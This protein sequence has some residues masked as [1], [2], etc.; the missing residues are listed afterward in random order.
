MTMLFRH[1]AIK[2]SILTKMRA[3]AITI[4]QGTLSTTRVH[5]AVSA[6]TAAAVAS[7]NN[8]Y[9]NHSDEVLRSSAPIWAAAALAVG[10]LLSTTF[11]GDD[12]TFDSIMTN[13]NRRNKTDC[14]GIAGVVGTTNKTDARYEPTQNCWMGVCVLL[15]LLQ[16]LSLGITVW[17]VQ[18]NVGCCL[19]CCD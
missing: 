6:V 12:A 13:S 9:Y 4:T 5:N 19:V 14:C 1:R 18:E 8:Y 16:L 7:N 2:S 15:L 17:R 3:S 10:V 11:P